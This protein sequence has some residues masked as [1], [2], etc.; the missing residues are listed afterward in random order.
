MAKLFNLVSL[1]TVLSVMTQ[2]MATTKR[3]FERISSNS[4]PVQYANQRPVLTLANLRRRT[5]TGQLCVHPLPSIRSDGRVW[6][7]VTA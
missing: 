3:K 5:S 6:A 7:A 4:H 2:T 1:C